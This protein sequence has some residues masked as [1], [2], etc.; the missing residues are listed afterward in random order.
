MNNGINDLGGGHAAREYDPRS[1]AFVD[2]TATG[3][4]GSVLG[5]E[6]VPERREATSQPSGLSTRLGGRG[7]SI[8][9]AAIGGGILALGLFLRGRA[10]AREASMLARLLNRK[11]PRRSLFAW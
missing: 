2:D 10:R 1:G 9:A 6:T 4:D 8:L 7:R 11:R 5:A 3:V